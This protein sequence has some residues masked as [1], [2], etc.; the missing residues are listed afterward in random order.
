MRDRE[1]GAEL[2]RQ[3]GVLRRQ[4]R[5][6]AA[7]AARPRG[8]A[9]RRR[10]RPAARGPRR[11]GAE[12]ARRAGRAARRLRLVQPDHARR[13]R[14]AR[15]AEVYGYRLVR[16][17][18]VDMFP[19]TPHVESVSAPRAPRD[20]AARAR[21][22]SA[23]ASRRR[24]SRSAFGS[25]KPS[26]MPG[27]AGRPRHVPPRRADHRQRRGRPSARPTSQNGRRPKRTLAARKTAK[28]TTSGSPS[29]RCAAARD[30]ERDRERAEDLR[31]VLGDLL[32]SARAR[33]SRRRPSGIRN[34]TSTT[35]ESSSKS[36]RNQP[37]DER[38]ARASLQKFEPTGRSSC[39]RTTREQRAA[40]IAG[41]AAAS[42]RSPERQREPDEQERR[43]DQ[44]RARSAGCSARATASSTCGADLVPRDERAR[45]SASTAAARPTRARPA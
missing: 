34:A 38:H 17:T 31:V 2:D 16:T 9:G 6:G 28:K 26:E 37:A 4:R 27:S 29:S 1:R 42:G 21:R 35:H 24:Q 5:R 33:P 7:R 23:A 25:R 45:A 3:R 13:R 22:R 41:R 20:Y 10:R 12:A 40:P 32:A 18:P 14:E 30:D 39:E 8:R 15:C 11:Q 43:R 44:R 36:V 19:H